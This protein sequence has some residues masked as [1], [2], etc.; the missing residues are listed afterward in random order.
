MRLIWLLALT[1][2]TSAANP[3]LDSLRFCEAY[4]ECAAVAELE[5][6]LCLGNSR[7]RPYWLP[8]LND[9]N[10]CHEKLRNDYAKLEKMEQDY[11]NELTKCLISNTRPFSDEQMET[12]DSDALRSAR[13]FSFGRT[14]SYV[15]TRC[16][17]GVKN[18]RKHEC[19]RVLDCCPAVATCDLVMTKSTSRKAIKNFHAEIIRRANDCEKGQQINS[20]PLPRGFL[21]VQPDFAKWAP[22]GYVSVHFNEVINDE[23]KKGHDFEDGRAKVSFTT[24]EDEY[25]GSKSARTQHDVIGNHENHAKN[26]FPRL[27][28]RKGDQQSSQPISKDGLVTL[29]NRSVLSFPNNDTTGVSANSSVLEANTH[30]NKSESNKHGT[31]ESV[32]PHEEEQAPKNTNWYKE[33]MEKKS[34]G[35]AARRKL[36]GSLTARQGAGDIGDTRKVAPSESLTV[37]SVEPAEPTASGSVRGLHIFSHENDHL[38]DAQIVTSAPVII[39]ANDSDSEILQ[40]TPSCEEQYFK[41]QA[42]KLQVILSLLGERTN[43]S[44]MTQIKNMTDHWYSKVKMLSKDEKATKLEMVK[45]LT[46]LINHFDDVNLQLINS[47]VHTALNYT[48]PG[49]NGA[50]TS[51]KECY[52]LEAKRMTNNRVENTRKGKPI[53]K[54]KFDRANVTH[55]TDENGDQIVIE[56]GMERLIL[57]GSSGSMGMS[58]DNGGT[59]TEKD[60]FTSKPSDQKDLHNTWMKQDYKLKMLKNKNRLN[61]S[62]PNQGRN[63][64]SCDL[65]MRCRNQMHL[66]VDSCAWRFANGKI[67]PTLAESAESLLYKPEEL[68]DPDE[69]PLYEDLYELII[70]RN[71]GWRTCLDKKNA[72]FVG[73]QTTHKEVNMF[74]FFD[75]QYSMSVCVPYS[76][77]EKSVFNSAFIRLLSEDYKRSS[78]CFRD[79]NL[80]QTKCTKLRHCCPNFDTC[81]Q[82]TLDIT[83]EQAIISKTA[84]LN[85]TRHNCLKLK[86]L[87]AFKEALRGLLGKS[88]EKMLDKLRQGKL[89]QHVMRGARA[90]ARLK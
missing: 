47:S 84:Q 71:Y 34:T 25:D 38:R 49:A 59:T 50:W 41:H 11:D 81:R 32:Q 12:C 66:A 78:D 72:I 87:E 31:E 1:C 4:V 18:R 74:S 62:S 27:Y 57:S 9:R 36:D 20:L 30:R 63:E 61:V 29:S 19:G 90:L 80:I 88:G 22:S 21:P 58:V 64:T 89:G 75:F 86:A 10:N 42:V 2:I 28:H 52:P 65:Y 68:C 85:Q 51:A 79:A 7:S 14:I 76:A 15:P 44:D 8:V 5:E 77:K 53:V 73:E 69:R 55:L 48:E 39:L 82:E 17:Q 40:P 43:S 24:K 33:T 3:Q 16:F 56:D 54:H 83:L 23:I 13:R 70:K 6:R 37:G 26:S 60:E 67:L 35:D 45:I 46:E